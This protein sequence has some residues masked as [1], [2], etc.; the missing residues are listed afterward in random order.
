[1][2]EVAGWSLDDR[3]DLFNEV[4]AAKN[5]RAEIIEKDFWVCWVLR[6]LFA[7]LDPGIPLIFKGGTS[8]SKVYDVIKRFSEDIDLSIDR[9]HFGFSAERDPMNEDL[10]G[11][12]R[13][14]LLKQ[15]AAALNENVEKVLMP[16][17]Q[18]IMAGLL[19][20]DGW[21]LKLSEDDPATILFHYPIATNSIDG[22]N[23][24]QPAVRLEFGA[25]GEIWPS[26][27]RSV[28]PYAA[29][30]FPDQFEKPDTPVTV[31]RAERTFW[32]KATILHAE[33][34]RPEAKAD[35]DRQ[36]RHYYDLVMMAATAIKTEA[37][38][39]I[40]LLTAVAEHKQVFFRSGWANYKAARPG[41]LHLTPRDDL[42]NL[43]E[44]DY[45]TMIDN[46]IIFDAPPEFGE[47]I[48]RLTNLED[49]INA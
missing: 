22:S 33:F 25:R 3:R 37:L 31:L 23:Y 41:S 6:R 49:E 7:D 15:I 17:L 38:E 42:R 40:D 26:D 47:L 14:R 32:E 29:E 11:N 4:S 24:L 5:L 44:R 45:K 1:M 13:A 10:S 36:S 8:L 18:G 27:R 28:I 21:A 30:A 46:G 34:H 9:S 12:E 2:D 20:E 19:G 43:L 48:T 35:A 16:K 39:N